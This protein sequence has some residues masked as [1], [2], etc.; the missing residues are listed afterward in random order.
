MNKCENCKHR[1]NCR[2][3]SKSRNEFENLKCFEYDE[4]IRRYQ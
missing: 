2:F 4:L 1:L 3:Y